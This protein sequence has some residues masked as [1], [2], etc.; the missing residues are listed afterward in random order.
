MT[1][2]GQL[3]RTEEIGTVSI[4]LSSGISIELHNVALAPTCDSN[5]ILLSQLRKSGI[6]YNDSLTAMTLIKKGKI[7]AQAKRNQNLFTL[8]LALPGQAM[9]VK[10]KAIMAV[11]RRGRPTHLVS[12]NKCVRIWHQRLAHISNAQIVRASMLVDGIELD[13]IDKDYDLAKVLIDS[14]N[15]ETSDSEPTDLTTNAPQIV[16]PLVTVQ[17]AA[18][19][20]K[21]P[22]P[23]VTA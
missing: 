1:V 9:S 5:L 15:S 11:K 13:T 8:N 21:I 19:Y 18:N 12:Q 14:D 7:I 23:S 17:A 16:E 2:S 22:E 20:Q 4:L 10:A 6:T 3:I